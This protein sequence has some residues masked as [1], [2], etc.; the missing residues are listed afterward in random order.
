PFP[1]TILI[2]LNTKAVPF[3]VIESLSKRL[4]PGSALG[5]RA[6][7]LNLLL[8]KR[9]EHSTIRRGP[10]VGGSH[11][12]ASDFSQPYRTVFSRPPHKSQFH[13]GAHW[14]GLELDIHLLDLFLCLIE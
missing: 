8:E 5:L 11:Q 10:C 12:A 7:R 1:D 13:T 6:H 2:S 9:P 14:T 3:P 4:L